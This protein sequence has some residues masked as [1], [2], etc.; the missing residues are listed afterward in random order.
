MN[1]E[2]L[3]F[4]ETQKSKYRKSAQHQFSNDI[5][6]NVQLWNYQGVFTDAVWSG[7]FQR[8][9]FKNCAMNQVR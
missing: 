2:G 5:A 7:E 6:L 3:S 9:Y 8:C 4:K 1:I